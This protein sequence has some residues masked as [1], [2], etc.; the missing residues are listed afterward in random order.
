M[1]ARTEA[2]NLAFL[3]AEQE[4]MER[5]SRAWG[6]QAAELREALGCVP[7]RVIA[8]GSCASA[9]LSIAGGGK[10]SLDDKEALRNM[11]RVEAVRMLK[12]VNVQKLLFLIDGKQ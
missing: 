5:Q 2:K 9:C 6:D 12:E 10:A 3:A 11:V 7:K 4:A 8:D 1:R